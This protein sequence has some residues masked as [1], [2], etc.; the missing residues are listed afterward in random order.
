MHVA[1]LVINLFLCMINLMIA[2]IT[3]TVLNK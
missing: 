3:L 1:A 2:E